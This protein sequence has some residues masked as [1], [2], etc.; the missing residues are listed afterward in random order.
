MKIALISA[1]SDPYYEYVRSGKKVWEI[2]L[3]KGGWEHMKEGEA[4]LL[5]H[6]SG[7]G[8]FIVVE[9]LERRE[10]ESIVEALE[11][12]GV[13]NAI[14]QAR[15]VEEALGEYRKFYSKEKEKKYGVVAFRVRVVVEYAGEISKGVLAKYLPH[16]NEEC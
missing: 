2:R 3:K 4:A 8:E 14:P 1:L 11:S 16:I 5:F 7:K 13:Q 10:F 9:V 12:V 6:R 15:S